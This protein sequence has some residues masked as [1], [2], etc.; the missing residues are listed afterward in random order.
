MLIQIMGEMKSGIDL[1]TPLAATYQNH[2][3][4]NHQYISNQPS[5][6]MVPVIASAMAAVMVPVKVPVMILVRV[7]VMV[8]VMVPVVVSV[9]VLIDS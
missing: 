1:S 2:R 3:D 8:L 7:P 4:A 9:M 6:G 5:L